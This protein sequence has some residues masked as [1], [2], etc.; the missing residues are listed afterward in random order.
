MTWGLMSHFQ[1]C[2]LSRGAPPNTIERGDVANVPVGSATHSSSACSS[3]PALAWALGSDS[4]TAAL[5]RA[6]RSD[7]QDAGGMTGLGVLRQRL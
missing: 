2:Y 4:E 6:G 1:H 3:A 5:R 7:A